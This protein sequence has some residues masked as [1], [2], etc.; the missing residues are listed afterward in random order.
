LEL[1]ALREVNEETGYSDVVIL[2]GLGEQLVA[3]QYKGMQV[4][5][6]EYYFLMRALSKQQQPRSE[7]DALQF[8]T[9]WVDWDEADDYLTYESEREW[10]KR[11]NVAY[12][13][14]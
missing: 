12:N 13:Q 4:Q 6:T 3:F 11:A 5:R 14:L 8:F 7:I 9:I 10:L 2:D 1:A